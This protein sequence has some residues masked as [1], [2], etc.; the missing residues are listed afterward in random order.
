MTQNSM[1]PGRKVT[2]EI[3]GGVLRRILIESP[4]GTR[5]NVF[6]ASGKLSERYTKR[7]DGRWKHDFYN[8]GVRITSI[9]FDG[10][11]TTTVVL[12][13]RGRVTAASEE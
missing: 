1:Q 8:K 11:T 10:M 2:R 7:P 9:E 3:K 12:D 6:D 13:V 4:M 5:A